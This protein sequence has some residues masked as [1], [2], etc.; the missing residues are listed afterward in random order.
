MHFVLLSAWTT[1]ALSAQCF[2][3]G[4]PPANRKTIFFDGQ[5][6]PI[7]LWTNDW[8][9]S[10]LFS[11]LW[12]ILTEEKLG[13]NITKDGAATSRPITFKLAGCSH[14]PGTPQIIEGTCGG[15]RTMHFSFESWQGYEAYLADA[16]KEF[17][18]K[19]PR[20]VGDI[21]YV[22]NEG[23]FILAGSMQNALNQS[24]LGLD[25]Y[26]NYN[27]DFFSPQLY[28]A[29][30]SDVDLSRLQT[31]AESVMVGFAEIAEQYLAATG[32]NDGVTTVGGWK[33]GLEM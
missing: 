1:T 25:F 17:G 32:D 21:G 14:V 15:V 13:Y 9:S 4:I 30:V 7:G 26:R 31:C 8:A 24:G 11:S 29:K 33:S 19:V 23:M 27:A 16:F 12:E 22:G 10:L 18:D 2:S 28:T 5:E 20:N 6:M 3:D